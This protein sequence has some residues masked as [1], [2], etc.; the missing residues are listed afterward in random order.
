MR[1]KSDS[2]EKTSGSGTFDGGEPSIE[3]AAP[4]AEGS[5][6]ATAGACIG[7]LWWNAAPAKIFMGD[8]GS[9]ALGG[10]SPSWRYDPNAIT[11]FA[12]R[13]QR[14]QPYT[15][16]GVLPRADPQLLRAAGVVGKFVEYFGHGL[17]GLPLADR[18]TIG[19]MSP[20]YGA[21]CGFFPVDDETLK[22]LRLTGRD[23]ERLALV[24]AYCKENAL[25]HD[26]DHSPEYSQVVE[27]DLSKVEPSLAGPRR[28]QDRVP[29]RDAKR[30][31]LDSL[32]TFGVDYGNSHDEGVA[33]EVRSGY[34]S[35]STLEPGEEKAMNDAA[36][37]Q[38]N[39]R[40][41][42]SVVD[43]VS[44]G[45][46]IDWHGHKDRGFG[47]SCAV[48]ALEAGA[49]RL[50]GAALGIGERCGNTPIDLLMVN[51]KLMGWIDNDLTSLP[52]YVR[53]VSAAVIQ[54]KSVLS[55]VH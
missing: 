25:W 3:E 43:E 12:D 4:D 21:T 24:E 37:Q 44:A 39:V 19:N 42:Q 10:I 45:V 26:P 47:V 34:R 35:H 48:A 55:I 38:D 5:A 53:F 18:A 28:P 36:K 32:E 9:L 22:Y 7:F 6:A 41:V 40:F 17:V 8:T 30:S 52:E 54:P 29:V 23:E 49:T 51:L 14:A 1:K 46:G 31:F 16:L 50:H 33:E 27:L 20:E 13:R 2:I 15:E 11:V